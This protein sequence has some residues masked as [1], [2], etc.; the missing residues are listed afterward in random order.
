VAFL[1]GAAPVE[2]QLVPHSRAVEQPGSLW[3]GGAL[4]KKALFL[5]ILLTSSKVY[6]CFQEIITD[7]CD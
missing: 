1:G 3:E 7:L 6:V 2:S 5:Y 4:Q